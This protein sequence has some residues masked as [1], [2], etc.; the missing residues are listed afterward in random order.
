MMQQEQTMR[1]KLI[2][3]LLLSL[4]L[5]LFSQINLRT[6]FTIEQ[7]PTNPPFSGR[8][9]QNTTA[10]DPAF[11]TQMLRATDASSGNNNNMI[12][13]TGDSGDETVFNLD[14]TMFY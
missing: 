1:T 6:D 2:L 13:I 11:G 10:T 8:L 9:G 4:S 3:L 5:N 7:N 14:D 12:F